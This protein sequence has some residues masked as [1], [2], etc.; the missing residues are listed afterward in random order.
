MNIAKTIPKGWEIKKIADLLDYERPDK[1]I[2]KSASYSDKNKIPVLTANKSFILGYTDEDFG[3]YENVPVII[4]DDF[5]TDSKF[6]DFAFKIKSSAI[7][8]L[9]ARNEKV[10]IK[11][12]YE[13]MKSINFPVGNHKRY[14]ISQYQEQEVA[15]P[16]IKEQNKIAEILS[17]LDEGIKKVDQEIKKTEELKRGL[18]AELLTKGIGHKKFKKTKLGMMPEEW[19]EI[20][21]INC[22]D[23]DSLKKLK[24]IKKSEYQTIG[25]YPVF[26]QGQE[27]ISGYT[28][29]EEFINKNY[30]VILFGDHT[31]VVKFINQTFAVGADGTKIFQGKRDVDTKFL[32]YSLLN[33]NIPNTGYNRHFKWVKE[34]KIL[35]PLLPE[36]IEIAQIISDVD[37]KI[38]VNKNIKN[39]LAELK[40]GLMQDLLGGRVRV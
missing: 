26:D 13:L 22:L 25:H 10:N 37:L 40:R 35:L 30:P 3:I 33:L 21:F 11:F 2:V 32:Y 8:I 23:L 1:Y 5:T 31:R 20:K 27:F 29:N 14:Y 34:S 9:K 7:K 24:G 16:P 15:T 12:V 19:R 39:K 6:V 28:N 17:S 36:Q 4:F 18:M 38:E